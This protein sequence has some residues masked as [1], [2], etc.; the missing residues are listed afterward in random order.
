MNEI[1]QTAASSAEDA[2]N[3]HEWE[4]RKRVVA[5]LFFVHTFSGALSLSAAAH[6]SRLASTDVNKTAPRRINRL[7][8][9]LLT[10][11]GPELPLRSS[12]SFTFV[13]FCFYCL[14]PSIRSGLPFWRS[15]LTHLG[16]SCFEVKTEWNK[17]SCFVCSLRDNKIKKNLKGW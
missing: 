6:R 13:S 7:T 10:R 15:P 9:C 1:K 5:A 3:S 11:P 8:S 14:F 12:S 17:C 4:E 2:G 16:W